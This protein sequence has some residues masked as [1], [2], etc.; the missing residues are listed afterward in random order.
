MPDFDVRVI[1]GATTTTW[2]D[3]RLTARGLARHLYRR[4]TR[5]TAPAVAQVVIHCVVDGVI[6]P[7]DVD[8]GGRL[9]YASRVSWSGGQPFAVVHTPG[10]TSIV[11]LSFTAAAL[12]HQELSI[13]RPEGGAIVLAFDVESVA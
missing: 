11:T 1:S 10:Q 6:A 12:G 7:L 13:R 8:L 5:P 3:P 4:V 9:F 2:D